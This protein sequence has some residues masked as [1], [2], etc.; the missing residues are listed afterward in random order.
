MGEF[1]KFYI[2]LLK[3]FFN[4][5]KEFF[6]GLYK[7]IAQIF[8]NI[9]DYIQLF[10]ER[11]K[12]FD[13]LGWVFSIVILSIN[14]AFVIFLL[15]RLLQFLRRYFIFRKKELDKEELLQEIVNLN[16]KTL[17]LQEEKNAIMGL[18]VS[19]ISNFNQGESGY[20]PGSIDE[21]L[22]RA[23]ER[24][25]NS[26]FTKLTAVDE[27][28]ENKNTR[29]VMNDTDFV[30][31]SD[32]VDR[33]VNFASS[34]L[35]LYYKADMVRLYFA[36]MATSK[37]MILEGISGTGKTSLPYAMGKFFNT[38]TQIIS[39]QPSWRDRAEI[40]GYLNE[41]TKK[42]NETDFLKAVYEVKYREDI[43]FVIL[44]EMNLARIEYYF[45]DFLSMMEMPD[46][47]EWKIDLVPNSLDTDP[48]L[49]DDGKILIPQNI[50]FI[51][52]AN[53]DDS[54]FTI[55]DKV[56][57]RASVIDFDKRGDYF[58]APYTEG[59]NM[60][61]EY[62]NNLFDDALSQYTI[63]PLVMTNLQKLD[64][65]IQAKFKLAFGNRILKQI[66][67]FVPVYMACGGNEVDG[68][69]YLF[70]RKILRK[71]E[72]LNIAFMQDEVEQLITLIQ[73]LFGKSKFLESVNYL[74]SMK[75]L[76]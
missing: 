72:S 43:N 27:V 12:Y 10:I 38:P 20:I 30:S 57:D 36:G 68:L 24:I 48:K 61:F 69:D 75:S 21:K 52:T 39:V 15:I 63:S 18:K 2:D 35:K 26:R 22:M 45:A 49:L 47:S 44:D 23:D 4:D 16:Q 25:A 56:Y 53:K 34:Q 41:F 60:S 66:N 65:F 14:I 64:D 9:W 29:I 50:W 31:L 37:L 28:Y 3:E 70:A 76:V 74:K 59:V 55:T 8:I 5:I 17:E 54:T 33:F 73:K 19:S 71:F 11:S 51:G 46:V 1:A 58:D 7:V 6:V 32:L 67:T 62:L 40:L 13:T 42:F